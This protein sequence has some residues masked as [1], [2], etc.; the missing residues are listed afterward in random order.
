M[1]DSHD[2][3]PAL[4][5]PPEND[6]LVGQEDWVEKQTCYKGERACHRETGP[7]LRP[8]YK[9]GDGGPSSCPLFLLPL[10]SFPLSTSQLLSCGE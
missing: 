9:W 8:I 6:H 3:R 5:H 2:A 1:D 10:S 4:I 7:D